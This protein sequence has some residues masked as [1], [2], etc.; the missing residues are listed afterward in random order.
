VRAVQTG[1]VI[2]L[3]ASVVLLGGSTSAALAGLSALHCGVS[4]NA[5]G[6]GLARTGADGLGPAD[7]V[8]LTRTTL[9]CGVPA[10]TASS[11]GRLQRWRRRSRLR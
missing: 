6:R 11:L 3:I 2:G 9:A 10:L 8:R 5:A 1:P 4:T 7:R